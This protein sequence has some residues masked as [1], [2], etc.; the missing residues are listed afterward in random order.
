[1][2]ILVLSNCPVVESQGSGYVV[3]GYVRE[4]RERGHD[5]NCFGPESFECLSWVKSARAWRLAI[6]MAAFVF[7]HLRGSDYD[8][9]ELYGG[10][11]WLTVLMLRVLRTRA[12]L[13]HHSNGLE[14]RISQELVA[15]FGADTHSGLPR[16]WYQPR[17]HM[18]IRQA[19]TRVDAVVVVSQIEFDFAKSMTYQPADRLL[20]LETPVPA[21]FRDVV[22]DPQRAMT[23]GYCGGWFARKGVDLVAQACTTLLRRHPKLQVRLA[24]VGEAF[25]VEEVFAADVADRVHVTPFI[26]DKLELR[27]W[28]Q[29]LAV[30]LMPSYSESFGLV[31]S[32]AMACGCAVVASKTGFAAS[33][34]TDEEALVVADY[35][36]DSYVHAV[37]RLL[38]DEAL[39]ARIAQA[40]HQRV[41]RM[42][43]TEVGAQLEA[44]YRALKACPKP[45][46]LTVSSS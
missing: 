8:L 3:T 37:D 16:R 30:L 41:Q 40:G 23:V 26:A 44:F 2:K 27:D 32:E 39:R 38:I 4:L 14:T 24:G 9:V 42:R 35:A 34:V 13:V 28:Y 33:L 7:R 46:L 6:G 18:L 43:W 17:A 45:P 22:F 20:S 12:V 15:N 1:M 25:R 36:A 5:V 31:V 19:F 21:V 10:E 11:S 29:Q